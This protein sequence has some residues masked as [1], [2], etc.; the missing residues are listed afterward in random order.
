[1]KVFVNNISKE[2]KECLFSVKGFK[3]DKTQ[4]NGLSCCYTC[5][6][7]NKLCDLEYGHQCNKLRCVL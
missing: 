3:A 1:M 2:P 6:M 7:N 5:S 4:K